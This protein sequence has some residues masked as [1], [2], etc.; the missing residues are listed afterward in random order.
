[1]DR[2]D[3]QLWMHP[4]ETSALVRGG[5]SEPSADIAARV[6]KAREIQR[7]R[8]AGTGIFCNAEMNGP[9]LEKYCPLDET[10]KDLLEGII[11][12]LGLSARAYTRVIKIARTIADLAGSAYIRPEH[13]SEAAMYRFLDRQNI[14]EM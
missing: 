13:L 4:V 6:L 14:L 1:M 9:Q 7:E 10:C 8:F 11:D 2:I 12:K 5:K 3:I